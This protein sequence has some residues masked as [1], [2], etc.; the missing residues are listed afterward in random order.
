MAI[1]YHSFLPS[2]SGLWGEKLHKSESWSKGIFN[3][4]V[5]PESYCFLLCFFKIFSL[6]CSPLNFQ[7]GTLTEEYLQKLGEALAV[8]YTII[9]N[10]LFSNIFGLNTHCITR[11]RYCCVSILLH[12]YILSKSNYITVHWIHEKLYLNLPSF[13]LK[14][15]NKG[16][17]NCTFTSQS[18]PFPFP[19][20]FLLP[21]STILLTPD[22]TYKKKVWYHRI[23]YQVKKVYY[24]SSSFTNFC[25]SC[26][27]DSRLLG[28]GLI[29]SW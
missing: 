9:V 7:S 21:L 23:V 17:Q 22:H 20:I 2:I 15:Q 29:L 4:S 19:M 10:L 18:L 6:T 11:I 25:F 14:L 8:C 26:Q 12:F 3:I 1:S 24:H 16:K 5:K 27:H 13:S 28:V